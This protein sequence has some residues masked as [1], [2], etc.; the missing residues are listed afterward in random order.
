MKQFDEEQT[1]K[2]GKENIVLQ[3]VNY[4]F[5]SVIDRVENLEAHKHIHNSRSIR[6]IDRMMNYSQ[7][8][9]RLQS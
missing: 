8:Y 3:D 7:K 9:A 1:Q 2:L 4:K 5:D 6:S